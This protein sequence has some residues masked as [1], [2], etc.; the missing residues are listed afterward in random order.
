M[1]NNTGYN[2]DEYG[3]AIDS[4]LLEGIANGIQWPHIYDLIVEELQEVMPSIKDTSMR[5][6]IMDR[7]EELG[8]MITFNSN[9]NP[10]E[11]YNGNSN[12]MNGGSR[13]TRKT[14]SKKMKSRKSKSRRVRSK[15]RKTL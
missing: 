10:I 3:K 4:L 9:G 14:K 15:A 5:E 11:K 7:F 6:Y 13:R 1:S 12:D 2:M 8:G